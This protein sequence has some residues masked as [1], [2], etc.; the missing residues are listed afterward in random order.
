MLYQIAK[1]PK[2]EWYVDTINNQKDLHVSSCYILP[3][4]TAPD[5]GHVLR[6]H[7][8]DEI[9]KTYAEFVTMNSGLGNRGPVKVSNNTNGASCVKKEI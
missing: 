6:L 7:D 5:D 8:Y 3:P 4:K 1:N 9:S 2:V